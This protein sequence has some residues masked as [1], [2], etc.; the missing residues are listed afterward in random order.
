M[1]AVLV[2]LFCN[3]LIT[4]R[5]GRGHEYSNLYG[6]TT[7]I[8]LGFTADYFLQLSKSSV[9][10]WPTLYV[11]VGHKL[12]LVF[13]IPETLLLVVARYAYGWVHVLAMK[14][15]LPRRRLKTAGATYAEFAQQC[16]SYHKHP[17][18]SFRNADLSQ[19]RAQSESDDGVQ[20]TY[21]TID[22]SK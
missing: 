6:N 10:F 9:H 16:E 13:S 17:F 19:E 3:I 18:T 2:F 20:P 21:H 5:Q 12:A 8:S 1:T 15:D 11:N 22:S 14:K 4:I 7:Q